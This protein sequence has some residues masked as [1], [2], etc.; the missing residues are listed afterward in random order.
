MYLLHWAHRNGC[1]DPVV[2]GTVELKQ[3]DGWNYANKT[4]WDC[5]GWKGIVTHYF[6]QYLEHKWPT[7]ANANYSATEVILEFFRNHP[8]PPE[9]PATSAFELK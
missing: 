5:D 6:E 9:S 1:T 3:S 2:N 4:T 7:V 8:L